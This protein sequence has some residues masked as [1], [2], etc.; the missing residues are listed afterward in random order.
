MEFV[1]VY[2]LVLRFVKMNDPAAEPLDLHNKFFDTN[3][4]KKNRVNFAAG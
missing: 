3:L 2:G 4:T 1:L